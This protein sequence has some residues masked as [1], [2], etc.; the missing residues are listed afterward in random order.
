MIR[1]TLKDPYYVKV[2]KL[3]GIT[4][5]NYELQVCFFTILEI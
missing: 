3:N 1:N 5:L 4:R 2:V